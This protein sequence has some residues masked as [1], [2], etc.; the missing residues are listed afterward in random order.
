M[1]FRSNLLVIDHGQGY[2]SI[3]GN[4]ESLLKQVGDV[5]RAGDVVSTVGASGGNPE[6]GLYFEMRHEGKALDPSKWFAMR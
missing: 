1:L 3:Y 4:N 6:S 2:L 5:I